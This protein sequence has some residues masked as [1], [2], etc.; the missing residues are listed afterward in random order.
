[1][2]VACDK[3]TRACGDGCSKCTH[4][5]GDDSNKCTH[6]L[7]NDCDKRTRVCNEV[8]VPDE[9]RVGP[10]GND[11]GQPSAKFCVC[12]C[13]FFFFFPGLGGLPH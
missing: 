10:P 6:V 5:C 9:C 1:M 13:F 3:C 4:V 8:R 2:S 11:I 12:V 7:G